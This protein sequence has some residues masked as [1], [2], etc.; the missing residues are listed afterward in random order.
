MAFVGC[1]F[2]HCV[3]IV[4]GQQ[5]DAAEFLMHLLDLTDLREVRLC[6]EEDMYLVNGVSTV[7][8]RVDARSKWGLST[9]DVLVPGENGAEVQYEVVGIVQYLEGH[10]VSFVKQDQRWFEYDDAKVTEL[11]KLPEVYPYLVFLSRKRR[12]RHY[13]KEREEEGGGRG[14]GGEGGGTVDGRVG[15]LSRK[16]RKR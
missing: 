4:E 2:K 1:V 12:K 5:H 9:Q 11:K 7:I 15:G 16:G 3:G 8:L 13:K 10:Y 6:V 14:G